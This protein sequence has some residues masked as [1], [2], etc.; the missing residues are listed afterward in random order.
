MKTLL[1]LV[2]IAV[3]A[4]TALGAPEDNGDADVCAFT[5]D[6]ST[7]SSI[8]NFDKKFKRAL[9]HVVKESYSD[10]S[11]CWSPNVIAT[12][13]HSSFSS[14]KGSVQACNIHTVFRCSMSAK[15]GECSK[16]NATSLIGQ[17]IPAEPVNAVVDHASIA[18]QFHHHPSE[19]L[20]K[21]FDVDDALSEKEGDM[22]VGI[23]Q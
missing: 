18:S 1:G 4:T 21:V 16:L 22:V 19:T 23:I 3:T 9:K 8:F 10:I 5:M 2:L 15:G 12:S 11:K 14:T 6:M 13:C 20:E 7:P 17:E